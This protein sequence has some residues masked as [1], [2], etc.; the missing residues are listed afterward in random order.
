MNLKF[1]KNIDELISSSSP[2][3]KEL[4]YI[5]ENILRNI[6]PVEAVRKNLKVKNNN[7]KIKNLTIDLSEI[8]NIYVVGG[9]KATLRM[10][11]AVNQILQNKITGGVIAVKKSGKEDTGKIEVI[12]AGHP[13]PTSDGIRAAKKIMD[14]AK[15]VTGRD[16][17]INLISGGGSA[18]LSA[19]EKD[20][21]LTEL[22]KTTELLLSSG[23]SINEINAIRKHC[24]GIKGGRLSE[25]ACPA[26]IV[27]L[28]ISDVVGDDLSTISSGPT[29]P[30]N[31][32]YNQ[33]LQV[34]K[35]YDLE[36]KIPDSVLT[37]LRSGA[38]SKIPETPSHNSKI[39]ERTFNFIIMNNLEALKIGKKTA[40]ESGYNSMILSSLIQ[41]DSR[42]AGNF[43]AAV[44]NEIIK[45][46]HPISPPAIIFS[47]GETTVKLGGYGNNK[48]GPNQETVLGFGEI[49]KNSIDSP[50]FLSIDSDGIDGN[51]ELAGGI[52]GGSKRNYS[53]SELKDSL[54][55]H[56]SSSFLKNINGGIVTG[57]TGTNVN[58]IRITGIK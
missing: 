29:Y 7:L 2:L 4:L 32:T 30:D 49:I 40:E 25:L 15:K 42:S 34:I 26:R 22:Q 56:S 24:S 43:H 39:F 5:L 38:K 51:S 57:E 27:S 14:I 8:E 54:K 23:A 47:G 11:Y 55:K 44:S 6:N 50:V 19:P 37:L 31:T 33:A 28:I 36:K 52:M 45:S 17:V 1:I 21:T 16:L 12:E 53:M 18:L 20:I 13:I 9:G 48:G 3:R 46:S 41:G 35:Y 10:V 58:D